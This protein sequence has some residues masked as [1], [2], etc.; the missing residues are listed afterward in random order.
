ML[1][2]TTNI[3][4]RHETIAILIGCLSLADGSLAGCGSGTVSVELT[5]SVGTEYSNCA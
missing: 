1:A 2:K 4:V 5:M 3:K